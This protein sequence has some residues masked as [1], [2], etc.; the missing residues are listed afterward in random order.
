M[1]PDVEGP[2]YWCFE[3]QR[4]EPEGEQCPAEDRLG[5]YPT[6]QEAVDWRVKHEARDEL[7]KEQDRRWE[8]EDEE[9]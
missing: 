3:H 9:G 2:W 7:W 1:R 4:A 8:G 5:P 6:R